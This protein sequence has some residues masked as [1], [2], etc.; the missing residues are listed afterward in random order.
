VVGK[1][2]IFCRILSEKCCLFSINFLI[3]RCHRY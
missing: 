2:K 1:F 3:W